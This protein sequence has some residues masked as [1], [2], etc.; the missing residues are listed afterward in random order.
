MSDLLITPYTMPAAPGFAQ[1]S[2]NM[3]SVA[4]VSRSPFTLRSQI[5]E[6]PG[7]KLGAVVTTPIMTREQGL[8]WHGFFAQLRGRV[9]TFWFGDS[10]FACK[11]ESGLGEPE[12][13]DVSQG[14]E[15][16]SVGWTPNAADVVKA[17]DWLRIGGKL[18][19]AITSAGADA[20]GAATFLVWPDMQA[21]PAGTAIVWQEPKGI[22]R[23]DDDAP[24][25]VWRTDRL[26]DSFT[27]TIIEA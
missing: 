6:W 22:F 19:K 20:D 21:V 12:T 15:V 13:V 14:R 1:V 5:Y 3:I 4:A 8:V 26:L 18:R 16:S 2:W 11:Q 23:L 7:Q 24:E 10:L 17:G 25:L 27:F 9:G